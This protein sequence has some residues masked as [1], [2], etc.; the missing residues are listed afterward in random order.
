MDL[1]C[2]RSHNPR[3]GSTDLQFH[4]FPYPRVIQIHR[5][6]E[7]RGKNSQFSQLGNPLHIF[8]FPSIPCP[9]PERDRWFSRI[10]CQF[11]SSQN[12]GIAQTQIWDRNTPLP[13]QKNPSKKKKILFSTLIFQLISNLFPPRLLVLARIPKN[14]WEH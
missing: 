14:T 8:N 3:M 12:P 11:G 6:T 9:A 2:P 7:F 10:S 5:N 13:K 1:E 4:P